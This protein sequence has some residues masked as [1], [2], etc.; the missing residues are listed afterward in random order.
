M[1]RRIWCSATPGSFCS[2]H[3]WGSIPEPVLQVQQSG[4]AFVFAG[5]IVLL[6][7]VVTVLLVGY[8]LLR[9][10]FDDLLGIVSDATGDPAVLAYAN[11]LAPTGKPAVNYAI[12]FPGVGTIVKIIAVQIVA[13]AYGVAAP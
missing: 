9:I 8:F 10:N 4:F 13:A 12:V 5:V 6:T 7:V 11:S 2:L 3:A 1:H